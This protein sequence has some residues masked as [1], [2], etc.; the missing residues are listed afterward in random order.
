[1][2]KRKL[3]KTLAHFKFIYWFVSLN[4]FIIY[5]KKAFFIKDAYTFFLPSPNFGNTG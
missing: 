3:E 4:Q 5:Q 2:A 1:M